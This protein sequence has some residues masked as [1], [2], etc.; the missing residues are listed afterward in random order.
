MPTNARFEKPGTRRKMRTLAVCAMAA[1]ASLALAIPASAMPTGDGVRAGKNITVF[2][3][4][5]S[6]AAYG[7]PV[8]QKL[9]IDLYRGDTRIATAFGPAVTTDQGGGLEVNH[10]VEGNT[11]QGDCWENFTPDVR[12][13][14]RIVVT[15][16]SGGTDQVLVDDITMGEAKDYA[17]TPDTRDVI[18]EGTAS[19]ADG[20]PVPIEALDGGAVRSDSPKLRAN[21]TRVERVEGTDNGWRAVYEAP[22]KV[23]KGDPLTPDQ[24]KQAILGGVHAMGYGNAAVLPPETQM[25]EGLGAGGPA[26]GCETLAPDA[27]ASAM[28]VA[29]PGLL[30]RANM[31]GNVSLSGVIQ[32]GVEVSLQLNGAGLPAAQVDRTNGTWSAQVPA[33]DFQEGD[34]EVK[35]TFSGPDAP[36]QP[37]TATVE[38]DT[39]PPAAATSNPQPGLYNADQLVELGASESRA[40]VFYTTGDGEPDQEYLGGRIPITSTTTIKTLTI[41]AAGN[42]GRI[43]PLTYEIDKEAPGLPTSTRETDSYDAAQQIAFGSQASDLKEIRYTAGDGS[44]AAPTASSG[45]VYDGEPIDVASTTTF[46]AVAVDRAGNASQ[47]LERTIS[48]RTATETRLVVAGSKLQAGKPRSI[49]G[50]VTP[51]QAGGTVLVTIDRPGTLSTITRSLDLDDFSRFV[52]VYKP[53]ATGTYKV[54]ASFVKD[55]DALDSTSMTKSFRVVR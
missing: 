26:P 10:G 50:S 2:G 43:T 33:A 1:L 8:G 9:T 41:D 38:K 25:V 6:V 21:P 20:T 22:Y 19:Y 29:S 16:S 4:L 11:V 31:D 36:A 48:I 55:T 15:D 46:K 37:Q 42:A 18:V 12:A 28:G 44:Q 17:A 39:T 27:P 51:N 54:S 23:F 45:K 47:V 34:N 53:K 32:E 13:G 24:G 30:T 14:D 52:F 3:N 40:R 7:H 35:A 5:D 49:A